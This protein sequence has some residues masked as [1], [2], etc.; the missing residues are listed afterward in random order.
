M[1]QQFYPARPCLTMPNTLLQNHHASVLRCRLL[2]GITTEWHSASVRNRVHLPWNSHMTSGAFRNHRRS[3]KR[4][5]L[6]NSFAQLPQPDKAASAAAERSERCH[7]GKARRGFCVRDSE[8][9][10]ES[11]ELIP[12]SLQIADDWAIRNRLRV[13]LLPFPLDLKCSP[14]IR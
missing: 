2:F 12:R 1:H 4:A 11:A 3:P 8:N 14:V 7:V 13:L 6:V 9:A 5:C 10:S